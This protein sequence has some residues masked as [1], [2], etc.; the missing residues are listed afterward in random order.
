[1]IGKWPPDSK[2]F[3]DLIAC[4]FTL[5]FLLLFFAI[6]ALAIKLDSSGPVFYRGLRSGLNG[7]SFRIFKFRTMVVD[8]EQI[9]GGTTALKDSRITRIGNFLR[10]YKLDE[11]PQV[12]NVIKGDMSIV[13]PRPELAQY[14]NLYKG[15]EVMILS[16]QPGITDYSSMKFRAL[17]EIVGAGDADRVYEETV[18]AE[19]NKLRIKYMKERTF[20]G[21]I[22][23]I[24]QTLCLI[25]RKTL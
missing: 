17:D 16:V 25:F 11:L 10:K 6:T 21:D 22:K 20:I 15:E 8:A 14:T 18:L 12:L 24:F 9:G 4:F 23:L 7:R 13:G 1:M 19:K 5:P 2:R 3:F